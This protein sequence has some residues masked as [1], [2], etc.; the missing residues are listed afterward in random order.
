MVRGSDEQQHSSHVHAAVPENLASP[1]PS[2][3]GQ[4]HGWDHFNKTSEGGRTAEVELTAGGPSAGTMSGE[5]EAGDAQLSSSRSDRSG[6]SGSGSGSGSGFGSKSNT[7]LELTPASSLASDEFFP[8]TVQ[9]VALANTSNLR[10]ALYNQPEVLPTLAALEK[11][12]QRMRVSEPTSTSS[13]RIP[14][15]EPTSRPSFTFN[16]A[17]AKN[18]MALD[19]I[20]SGAPFKLPASVPTK[21]ARPSRPPPAPSASVDPTARPPG[22]PTHSGTS[23]WS[24]SSAKAA[25]AKDILSPLPTSTSGGPT[26]RPNRPQLGRL[27]S[28]PTAP[29]IQE[30]EVASPASLPDLT[31]PPVHTPGLSTLLQSPFG[32]DDEDAKSRSTASD[33]SQRGGRRRPLANSPFRSY[34][35]QL[36][37][38]TTVSHS[39]SIFPTIQTTSDDR[40][41]HRRVTSTDQES[42]L[43]AGRVPQVDSPDI[44]LRQPFFHNFQPLAVPAEP[45]AVTE[46]SPNCSESGSVRSAHSAGSAAAPRIRNGGI[47]A[48]HGSFSTNKA[49]PLSYRDSKSSRRAQSESSGGSSAYDTPRN[50]SVR[51]FKAPGAD[52]N[53]VKDLAAIAA[54]AGD[55]IALEEIKRER[56]Q[57]EGTQLYRKDS[58]GFA[59]V[60]SW[61]LSGT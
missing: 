43:N 55:Q 50:V 12:A 40:R 3:S 31:P 5:G 61:G 48:P 58:N 15:P 23:G 32:F 20:V 37:N 47:L 51:S 36:P 27:A 4:Q 42:L 30:G 28:V 14:R 57:N 10:T 34:H 1:L 19:S 13:T 21:Q 53:D 18:Q 46:S 52:E 17:S 49:R 54:A 26:S 11:A 60:T 38:A 44:Q 56:A 2:G 33:A 35:G 24:G 7:S 22:S 39:P 59:N 41:G 16:S 29:T 9:N 8:L 25:E 6:P 45:S